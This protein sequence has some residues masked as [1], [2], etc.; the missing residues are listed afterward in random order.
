MFDYCRG[1]A[2][3]QLVDGPVASLPALS[4][5]V[6]SLP[7]PSLPPLRRDVLPVAAPLEELFPYGGLARGGIV[8]VES[9]A[10]ALALVASA[11]RSGA[12]C[13]VTGLPE[14]GLAAAVEAGLD[15]DRF[16]VV[17]PPE[18]QWATAVAALLDGFPVVLVGAPRG[19]KAGEARR[20]SARVREQR[21]VLVAV[22]GWPESV[23][24]KVCLDDSEWVGLH[25]GYGRLTGRRC[26]LTSSGRG[27]AARERQVTAWLPLAH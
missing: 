14:L 13:A 17:T 5:P 7:V 18:E 15:V 16:V 27:A 1:V 20:L 21:G 23:D 4:L 2:L 6:S 19:A 25:R 12:W 24:L 10:V 22:G 26:R 8:A 11:S 9:P 3:A